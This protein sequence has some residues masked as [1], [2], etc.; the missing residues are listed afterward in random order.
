MTRG[1]IFIN[2][3]PPTAFVRRGHAKAFLGLDDRALGVMIQTGAI[4]VMQ[5]NRRGG[6][7]KGRM[8]F[9]REQLVALAEQWKTNAKG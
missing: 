4:K 5:S 8:Y 6:K 3:L 2:Q 9:F 7:R 1:G